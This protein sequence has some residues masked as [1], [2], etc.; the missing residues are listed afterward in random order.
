MTLLS[1]GEIQ[2]NYMFN[3]YH[4]ESRFKDYIACP[5]CDNY[6]FKIHAIYSNYQI[7][8][9]YKQRIEDYKI[10]ISCYFCKFQD[11]LFIYSKDFRFA[12]TKD[13]TI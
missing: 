12:K 8:V 7:N 1:L 9:F 13:I 11:D 6:T 10:T 2:Y 4:I 3:Y 5:V